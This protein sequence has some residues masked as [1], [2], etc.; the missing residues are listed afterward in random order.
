ME[1]I[2]KLIIEYENNIENTLKHKSYIN[3]VKE[4]KGYIF[5]KIRNF[6]K[7]ENEVEWL[8][9]LKTLNYNVP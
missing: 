6:K 4:Y 2:E 7:F 5:K 3:E 9:K 8:K 1:K